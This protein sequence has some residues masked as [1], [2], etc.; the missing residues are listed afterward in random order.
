MNIKEVAIQLK[1]TQNLAKNLIETSGFVLAELTDEQLEAL[2]ILAGKVSGSGMVK[3]NL[4][5]IQTQTQPSEIAVE[6][7]RVSDHENGF[8]DRFA[9][10]VSTVRTTLDK[11]STAI[12][13]ITE[14]YPLLLAEAVHVKMNTPE[15]KEALAKN[16]LNAAEAL[17]SLF[18]FSRGK[19]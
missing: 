4:G 10:Y 3:K 17:M 12:T 14:D 1:V 6:E 5:D 16:A 2:K 7:V 19:I 8:N 11:E 15:S 13:R 9:Q 18:D